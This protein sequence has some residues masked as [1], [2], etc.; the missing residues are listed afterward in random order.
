M[1]ELLYQS[2]MSQFP[3]EGT[4][5]KSVTRNWNKKVRIER[6]ANHF[7]NQVMLPEDWTISHLQRE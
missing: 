7:N 6:G 5:V 1:K 4:R 3:K 2:I